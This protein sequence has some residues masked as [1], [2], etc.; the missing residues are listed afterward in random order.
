MQATRNQTLKNLCKTISNKFCLTI[1]NCAI[2]TKK[3]ETDYK[4]L[5]HELL[6]KYD[7]MSNQVT[8]DFTNACDEIDLLYKANESAKKEITS[9]RHAIGGYITQMARAKKEISNLKADYELAKKSVSDLT[10]LSLENKAMVKE[11]I[12]REQEIENAY[13]EQISELDRQIIELSKKLEE[14]KILTRE[15]EREKLFF[16]EN[17]HYFVELPWYKRIFIK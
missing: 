11:C 13:K 1:K 2:M 14:Q 12:T 8:S 17:Y 3:K 9:L 15:A 5:Y 10:N 6:E 7:E 16:K 4:L